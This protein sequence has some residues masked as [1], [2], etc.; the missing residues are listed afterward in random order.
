M[1][2]QDR[3][4]THEKEFCHR[5]RK[6][7]AFFSS[8]PTIQCLEEQQERKHGDPSEP[9]EAAASS[10]G[11]PLMDYS[12]YFWKKPLSQFTLSFF[13]TLYPQTIQT[14]EEKKSFRNFAS[15]FAVR[16]DR[17]VTNLFSSCPYKIKTMQ[18]LC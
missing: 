1:P 5:T 16:M 6:E 13:Y 17:K 15:P 8:S 9:V 11:E 18:L 10:A 4:T 2:Y 7:D 14:K 3:P 12:T